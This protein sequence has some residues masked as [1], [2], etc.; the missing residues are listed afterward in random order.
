M[1]EL[2]EVQTTVNGVKRYVAGLKIRA[3][4]TDYKSRFHAGKDNI[5]DPRYFRSFRRRVIGAKI[6]GAS[7]RGKNV[8]I[9]LSNSFIILVHMK[10]TG[11]LLYG[12]Y[13]KAGATWAAIGP[14]P[15]RDDPFNRYI[16]LVL[17]LSNGKSL[18]LSDL[19]KFAKVTLIETARIDASLHISEH[20]PEPL[21]KSFG[22]EELRAALSRRPN[23]PI[24]SALM[25]H[26]LVSGIGNIYSDEILWRVGIHPLTRVQTIPEKIW[27]AISRVMK[28]TLRKGIDFGGDSMSDY[29][30][31]LGGSGRFQS[32]H[33]AYRRTGERCRKRGCG[34]TIRRLVIGS[35]SAHFCDKHQKLIK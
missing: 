20:G 27:P 2:P 16:H 17:S 26:R 30:D 13:K 14:G 12:A 1:P 19:R 21:E 35:R 18:V 28:E 11:H 4:W 10:M 31:I 3:A 34:G 32:T 15:L 22:P 7:R 23:A 9:H 24:K 8:L 25:D 33:N 5:Q 29:R 6:T